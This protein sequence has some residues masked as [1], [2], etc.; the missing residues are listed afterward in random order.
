[1]GFILSNKTLIGEQYKLQGYFGG[2]SK[3]FQ[4]KFEMVFEKP[5]AEIFNS[6][7]E[8]QKVAELLNKDSCWDFE[9]K[10]YRK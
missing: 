3:E 7:D 1:M 4:D 10:M 8:A 6:K 9:V 5:Y 2:F